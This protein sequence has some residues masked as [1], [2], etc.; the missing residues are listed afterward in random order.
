MDLTKLP[1]THQATI[2]EEYMD[3]MGHMN[4][5]WYT[6]HFDQAT[7]TFFASFGMGLSYFE[8]EVAGSFAMEQHTRY[9]AEVLKEQSITLRTRA[10]GRSQRRIHFMHSMTIQESGL[11]AA[12]TELVGVHIDLTTRRSSPLPSHIAC[13]F[14]S[15]LE[16]HRQL[17]WDAPSCGVMA[18]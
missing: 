12:T 1:L 9:L 6:H 8:N 7:W 14:D 17:E 3:E 2:T 18:P 13:S 15:L 16:Q 5:M 11:L 4:V 10:L